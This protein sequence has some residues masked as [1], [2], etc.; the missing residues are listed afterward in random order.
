MILEFFCN[1]GLPTCI[2]SLNTADRGVGAVSRMGVGLH[3]LDALQ[4]ISRPTSTR[5]EGGSA[6]FKPMRLAPFEVGI[7]CANRLGC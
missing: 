2:G 6:V 3:G 1:N 4:T 5:G 7:W